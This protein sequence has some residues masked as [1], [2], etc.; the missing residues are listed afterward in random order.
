MNGTEQRAAGTR[1]GQLSKQIEDQ[2]LVIEAL[3]GEMVT[4]RD[5][6]RDA[7]QRQGEYDRREAERLDATDADLQRSVGQLQTL[8]MDLMAKPTVWQRLRWLVT[9]RR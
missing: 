2:G 8:V 6:V 5:L 1:N 4:D 9:R 3:A 7:F